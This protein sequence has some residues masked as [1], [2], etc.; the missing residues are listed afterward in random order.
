MSESGGFGSE[1]MLKDVAAYVAKNSIYT[2]EEVMCQLQGMIAKDMPY[3]AR[4]LGHDSAATPHTHADCRICKKMTEIHCVSSQHGRQIECQACGQ[5]SAATSSCWSA[6]RQW[7]NENDPP[8][9][10]LDQ[11]A[12]FFGRG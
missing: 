11:N 9:K 12:K 4:P 7:D 8:R 2:E 6:I 5:R 10:P 1:K 3:L